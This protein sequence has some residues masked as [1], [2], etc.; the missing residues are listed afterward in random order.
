MLICFKIK[1][2]FS[3]QFFSLGYKNSVAQYLKST[4]TAHR[5]FFHGHDAE[6]KG[7]NSAVIKRKLM[8]YGQKHKRFSA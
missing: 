8:E 5:T 3:E 1:G 4:Q 6:F 2:N 7:E